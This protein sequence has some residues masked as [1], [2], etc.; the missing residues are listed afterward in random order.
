MGRIRSIKPEFTQNEGLS[1]LPPETHL[2]A[3]GLL[4]YSDD[5][6]FFNANLG[7]L[8]AS[9][10]PLRE[11]SL[12]VKEMLMQLAGIA[13]IRLGTAAGGKQ[14]G[15]IV[16]FLEHQRVNRPT[17]SKIGA[18]GISWEP[19]LTTH[20][21]LT[22][23]SLPE[24]KGRERNVLFAE[25]LTEDSVRPENESE[26]NL[27]GFELKDDEKTNSE[28]VDASLETV[29]EFFVAQTKKD[30]N[31]YHLTPKRKIRGLIRLKQCQWQAK[32][33]K[34]ETAVEIMKVAIERI[35]TSP[36]HNGQNKQGHRYLE[37]E[38]HFLRRDWDDFYSM[39]LDDSNFPVPNTAN[40]IPISS[41]AGGR[42]ETD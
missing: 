31:R 12:T 9:V 39:W 3:V 16:K 40:V 14:Y 42:N 1:A 30:P 11:T 35:A 10:F 36:F 33:G 28:R 8:K 24:G 6:G 21:G 4:C 41:P 22:E 29:F 19:S 2:F 5:W 25:G 17:P 38:T 34:L 23:G 27:P 18:L 13:F 20:S 37:W 26:Q 7:L 32:D 15:H